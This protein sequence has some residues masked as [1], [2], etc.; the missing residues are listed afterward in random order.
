MVGLPGEERATLSRLHLSPDRP[1]EARGDRH[2]QLLAPRRERAVAGAQPCLRLPGD[3]LHRR[4]QP[5]TQVVLL[6]PGAGRVA[7]GP[8]ALDEDT[9]QPPVP[10]L[11]DAEPMRRLPGRAFARH[12]PEVAHELPGAL[13]PPEVAD[14]RRY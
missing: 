13:E 14:L 5:L 4:R 3:V 6:L 1:D 11:G 8:G 7:V 12:Q 2:G 10:G 9:P